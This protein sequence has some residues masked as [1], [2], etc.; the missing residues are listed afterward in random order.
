MATKRNGK[1]PTE[2]SRELLATATRAVSRT[3][4]AE[5]NRGVLPSASLLLTS[6]KYSDGKA[7]SVT[8]MRKKASALL[9]EAKANGA[10]EAMV[11]E[12]VISTGIEGFLPERYAGYQPVVV[13]GLI[14][15]MSRLPVA[16]LAEKV[17]DQLLLPADA[18]PGLRLYT[19]I[20]DMPTLQ[21]LGQVICRSPGLD[22]AFKRALVDLEDNIQT[23]SMHHLN[24]TLQREIRKNGS[25]YGVLPEKK[26]LAEASVC[27]VVPAKVRMDGKGQPIRAVLKV[28]KPRVKRNMSSELALIDRLVKFL[29]RKKSGWGLGEFNFEST[30]AQVRNILANEVDLVSEQRN[31]DVARAHFGCDAAVAIPER[32]AA[33]TPQ[34]T[35]M[36]RLEGTKITEVKGLS[37]GQR[38][39]LA[40]SIA[41]ICILGPI[42]DMRKG[43]LFHGDPHAGNLAYV[44][45]GRRPQIIFYDWGM[46]GRLTPQERCAMILLTIGL[47]IGSEKTIFYTSDILTQ[48]QLSATPAMRRRIREIVHAAACEQ[49]AGRLGGVSSIEFLFEKFTHEGVVF[50]SDLMM[51]EKAL[52]TLK[53]VLR[54]IDP[55]FKRDVYMV[56]GAVAL[57]MDDLFRLRLMGLFMKEAW[58]LYCRSIS[59]I[60]DLQKV[61][62]WLSQDMI[63]F[64]MR[65]PAPL[66]TVKS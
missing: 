45:K 8:T 18:L 21:K 58:R 38:R 44:F 51:Y 23:V 53:G 22:P 50:S 27:A 59:L 47:L 26:I 32:L 64:T 24:A 40:A 56:R 65:L 39:R 57:F 1:E 11:R 41:D 63:R 42:Q 20:K 43:G 4:I 54:D 34:M 5:Q 61:I 52:L 62:F 6:L 13:E 12:V 7:Q 17:V 66:L 35:A 29:D 37:K 10:F 60:I 15:M 36:T 46:L 28:V 48:G 25:E 19:L 55:T 16:R 30:L 2:F 31:I 3:V 49:K 9:R 14:F 33:S